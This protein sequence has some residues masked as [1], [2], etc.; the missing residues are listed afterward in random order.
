M[1]ARPAPLAVAAALMAVIGFGF[2]IVGAVL[3]A[4]AVGSMRAA[5]GV[6]VVVAVLGVVAIGA[7]AVTVLAA[8]ALWRRRAWGWA[9]SLTIALAAVLGAVIAMETAVSQAPTMLGLV[10]AI[11]ATALLMT[12]STRSASTIA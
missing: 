4:G 8:V 2:A 9:G 1:T 5:A 6:A 7:A 3:L 10:V 12:P 11:V